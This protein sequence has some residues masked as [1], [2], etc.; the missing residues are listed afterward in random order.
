MEFI[1]III[2][3]DGRIYMGIVLYRQD[4]RYHMG[5]T[6]LIYYKIMVREHITREVLLLAAQ[7]VYS[8]VSDKRLK[9]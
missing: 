8:Y 6:P 2:V 4:G 1:T 3:G 9:N 7:G 5:V